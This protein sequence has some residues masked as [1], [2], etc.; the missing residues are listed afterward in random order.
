MKPTLGGE[1]RTTT[2]ALGAYLLTVLPLV[3]RE[4]R[5]WHA[6]AEAIAEPEARDGALR[7]LGAKSANVEAVG[8]L[9]TLAPI[10][11][12]AGVTRAIVPLQIAIDYRDDLEEGVLASSA[13]PYLSELNA[14]WRRELQHL[15]AGPRVRQTVEG[16]LTRCAEGQARTHG[17]ERGNLAGLQRWGEELDE[18]S[19]FLWWELAAGAS[20]S[21]AAHA[22]I[23]SAADPATDAEIA[24]RID[25][26]YGIP[27]GA[28]TVLL[29]DFIDARADAAAGSHSYIAYYSGA[30]ELAERLGFISRQALERAAALP[31]RE[32]HRAIIAGIA[33]FYLSDPGARVTS[34]TEV[35]TALAAAIGPSTRLIAAVMAKRRGIQRSEACTGA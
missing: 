34:A 22:L 6:R 21:V 12:R 8:A 27:I 23:A 29:D 14:A 26:T 9:A 13:E 10:R 32:R 18:G 1:I 3:R 11:E 20:S 25:R 17:A 4:L 7:T 28:L 31:H 5:R 16:A 15:P 30:G 35:S 2:G 19:G 33:G 24:A